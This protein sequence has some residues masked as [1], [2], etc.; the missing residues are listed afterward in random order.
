MKSIFGRNHQIEQSVFGKE[1]QSGCGFSQEAAAMLLGTQDKDF[2]PKDMTEK[3]QFI[4]NMG[5]TCFEID[6]K[7]LVENLE[8]V[9]QAIDKTGLP[10]ST[11][12]GG[13]RGWIGDFIEEKRLNGIEDLK[14]IL[15]AIKEVGGT[16][17]VVPAAWGMFTFRL[18]PMVSPRSHEGDVKAVMDSLAK[19]EQTAEETGTYL[20]LEAL[21]RYQDHMLNTQE[22]AVAMIRQGGFQR[23][24]LTCDFY[25]MA[26]EEDDISETLKIQGF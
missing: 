12:C 24:K 10:V 5:F 21:N 3:F 14:A 25:H 15:H 19:L 16:G 6:G 9:K 4:K 26:I 8:K 18:P 20:Y 13:Y 22:D 17:V 11:A 1:R 2:F 23:V 7:E